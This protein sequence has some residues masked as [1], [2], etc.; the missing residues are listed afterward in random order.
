MVIMAS[1][2]APGHESTATATT[3]MTATTFFDIETLLQLIGRS[4][5]PAL[6]NSVVDIHVMIN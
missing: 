2:I 5:Y 4:R 3:M 6:V 1:V